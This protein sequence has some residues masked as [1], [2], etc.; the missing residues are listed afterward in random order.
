[1]LV[2]PRENNNKTSKINMQPLGMRQFCTFSDLNWPATWSSDLLLLPA[3]VLLIFSLS[4]NKREWE[5]ETRGSSTLCSI[6]A[7]YGKHGPD[8]GFARTGA[9]TLKQGPALRQEVILHPLHQQP[10]ALH[11][12]PEQRVGLQI[13]QELHT[14]RN[15]HTNMWQLLSSIPPKIQIDINT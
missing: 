9:G 10:L 4:N 13:C 6:H 15:T 14:H 7:P 2:A 3:Q 1:M 8:G 5:R 11:T 12:V